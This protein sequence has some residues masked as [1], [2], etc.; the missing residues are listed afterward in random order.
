MT[1]ILFI[2]EVY[3]TDSDFKPGAVYSSKN[4]GLEM[5]TNLHYKNEN[6]AL[7]GR[8]YLRVRPLS[9][10]WLQRKILIKSR[11][12]FDDGSWIILKQKAVRKIR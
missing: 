9:S 2:S 6:D 10:V 12:V 4:V 8:W 11:P 3:Q 5:F 1:R 7:F